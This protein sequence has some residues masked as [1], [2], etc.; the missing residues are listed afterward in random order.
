MMRGAR[1]S[2]LGFHG[3]PEFAGGPGAFGMDPVLQ[4]VVQGHGGG[5]VGGAGLLGQ[6]GYGGVFQFLWQFPGILVGVLGVVRVVLQVAA[7]GEGAGGSLLDGE[8]VFSLG[9]DQDLDGHA[10]RFAADVVQG[11]SQ[12]CCSSRLRTWRAAVA[13]DSWSFSI[14]HL[15]SMLFGP[16]QCVGRCLPRVISLGRAGLVL[17]WGWRGGVRR[18]VMIIGQEQ[19]SGP[20]AHPRRL[21]RVVALRPAGNT[22]SHQPGAVH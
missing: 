10:A 2:R 15:V 18:G 22:G 13:A 11:S 9:V 17:L 7:E 1:F 20:A 21:P 14:L 12:G 5:E 3:E 6:D 4:G 16:G 8:D 19:T